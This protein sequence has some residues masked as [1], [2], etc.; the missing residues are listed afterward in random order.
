M[1]EQIK[2]AVY[3]VV[4]AILLIVSLVVVLQHNKISSLK[5]TVSQMQNTIDNK[6]MELKTCSDGV[7]EVE[8]QQKELSKQ[9][10]VALDK[11]KK[12]AEEHYGASDEIL[13]Y[14]PGPGNDC[15]KTSD[16]LNHYLDVRGVK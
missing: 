10:K 8:K 11:A 16:L 14:Q 9:L 13:I 1:F 6:T 4:L 3:A 7:V 15:E 5:D 2:T 12:E